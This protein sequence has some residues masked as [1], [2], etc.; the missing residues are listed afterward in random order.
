MYF[1]LKFKRL[2]KVWRAR[3]NTTKPEKLNIASKKVTGYSFCPWRNVQASLT[4]LAAGIVLTATQGSQDQ[5]QQQTQPKRQGQRGLGDYNNELCKIVFKMT[6]IKRQGKIPLSSPRRHEVCSQEQIEKG[7]FEG[8]T[9][10][11]KKV[12]TSFVEHDN[13]KNFILFR[14]QTVLFW[15]NWKL[16][17]APIKHT[18]NE[19]IESLEKVTVRCNFFWGGGYSGKCICDNIVLSLDVIYKEI[20]LLKKNPSCDSQI[21]ICHILEKCERIV[22]RVHQNWI[23]RRV[24]LR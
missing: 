2:I 6:Q 14:C 24:T 23:P 5:N 13:L 4:L 20:I 9:H 22:I 12:S 1:G 21:F 10:I 18:I 15:L 7:T 3:T 17:T 16:F 11:S 8:N 19:L